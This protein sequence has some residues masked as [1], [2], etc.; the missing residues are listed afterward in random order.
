MVAVADKDRDKTPERG[1]AGV[2]ARGTVQL[3]IGR[4]LFMVS[5]YLITV[6]LARGLGPAAYGVYGVIMSLLLWIEVVGDLGIQRATI[7]MVPEVK[8]GSVV[9]QTSAT[10]LLLVSVV[11][12]ALCWMAAPWVAQVFALK[13]G[14]W[15][16]RIAILDL[17]FNGIYLAYQG[18]LQG[19]R[20]FGTL[21]VTL[22]LYSLVKLLG[23]AA[24]LLIGLSV[25]AALIVNVLATVGALIFLFTQDRPRLGVPDKALVKAMIAVA[26]PLGVFVVTMQ[27]LLSAH[28]WLLKR[29]ATDDAVIGFYAAAFNL[30]RLPTVVPFVLTGVVL[31][32]IS[33]A[34][35]RN[36]VPLA[37]H[38]LQAAS[39][40]ILVVLFPVC[41]LGA[42]DAGPIMGFV[43][44]DSYL[45]GGPFLAWL[46]V[47]FG[48]FSLLDTLLHALIAAGQYYRVTGTLL[49]LVPVTLVLNLVLIPEHGA[50][51]A[52]VGFVMTLGA[53]TLA[54]VF[55]IYQRYGAPGTLVTLAR[56]VA[57]TVV[58]ALISVQI[59]S[60]GWWLLVK[61]PGLLLVYAG[62]LTLLRELTSADLK[63]L[64]VWKKA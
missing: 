49:A 62:V 26:A 4:G 48:L 22:I 2:A 36:D 10:L 64:A 27:F 24:L 59:E 17:P 31:A 45:A 46:L 23:I 63:P 33:L 15:L 51:G 47:A 42:I 12:F 9:A 28:L 57:A 7:K 6:I 52:A 13:D 61:L 8:D 43:F 34:L 18:V 44:S 50:L 16:F 11:L 20:K 58:V 3:L 25:E 41:V 38:Y 55:W 37:R 19:Y 1:T 56:T 14:A 29:F 39:R 30:A 54:A 5:G 32:S 40:F 53:G 21:A 35:A 60:T